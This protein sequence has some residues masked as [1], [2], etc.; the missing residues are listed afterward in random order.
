MQYLQ[1]GEKEQAEGAIFSAAVVP[2]IYSYN[3]ESADIIHHNLKIGARNVDFAAVKMAFEKVYPHLGVSCAD[4]GGL[5]GEVGD[6]YPGA[7]PCVD[8]TVVSAQSS[9]GAKVGAAV[10]L[11]SGSLVVLLIGFIIFI[12]GRE[13]AGQPYFADMEGKQLE[14]A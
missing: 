14:R 7:A 13:K 9:S 10:G 1:G 8:A 12:R 4:V 2:K 3:K 11:V 6:Y 5:F